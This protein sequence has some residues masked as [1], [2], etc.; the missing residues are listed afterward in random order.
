MEEKANYPNTK[1]KNKIDHFLAFQRKAK[2]LW[3][4]FIQIEI[5]KCG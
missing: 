2:I 1:N 5:L 4:S 3:I